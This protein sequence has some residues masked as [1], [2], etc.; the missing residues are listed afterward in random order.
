MRTQTLSFLKI[1][2]SFQTCPNILM[3]V[4]CLWA[5][6]SVTKPVLLILQTIKKHSSW[7]ADYQT[8]RLAD[9]STR[10]DDIVTSYSSKMV[11][12]A[13]SWIKRVTLSEAAPS[14]SSVSVLPSKL[15]VT[16]IIYWMEPPCGYFL[17]LLEK[18]CHRRWKVVYQQRTS[19]HQSLHSW[20]W[21]SCWCQRN[22]FG[23]TLKPPIAFLRRLQT[24]KPL[25]KWNLL[26]RD[27]P[28]QPT[29]L[30][31]DM[32]KIYKLSH[33]R[34]LTSIKSSLSTTS[35]LKASTSPPAIVSE[36]IEPRTRKPVSPISLSR[37]RSY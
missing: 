36:S 23:N 26:S 14:R 35:L 21:P 15:R 16:Q 37:C 3:L 31:W 30:Q 19:L 13:M 28:N 10:F 12:K 32:L 7:F 17:F 5:S 24:I 25:L 27:T 11:K 29:K 34:M 1:Y 8:Y 33:V 4:A 18:H 20:T 22:L 6:T 9:R 2:F